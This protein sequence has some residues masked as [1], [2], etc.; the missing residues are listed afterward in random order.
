[1]HPAG[2]ADVAEPG[3]HAEVLRSSG[4]PLEE[5]RSCHGTGYAGG[6]SGSSCVTAGCHTDGVESCGTCHLAEPTTAAHV[7][8]EGQVSCIGCHAPHQN[9]RER[10]HPNGSVEVVLSGLATAAG[11]HPQWESGQ[12]TCSDVYCHGGIERTWVGEGPLGCDGCHGHPPTSHLGFADAATDCASC[13]AGDGHH[14]DGVL[15]V[16]E[17]TC[18]GCHGSGPLGAPPPGLFGVASGGAVGAH[19]RHLDES[20]GDRIGPIVACVECHVVPARADDDGHLDTS[21]PADVRLLH[22]GTYSPVARSCV[23]GCHSDRDPGPEW[24]D[25]S[26]AARECGG[27]HA[28]PPATVASGAAHP[29]VG[30]APADCAPC[31]SFDAATHVDGHVD[32]SPLGC[33]GCHGTG[34]LGAPP[35]GLA[36]ELAGGAVGAHARHLDATLVDRVGRAAR[37]TDCHEVPDSVE[38]D[39]HLDSSP[40]ADVRLWN[41]GSYEPGPRTCVAGCHW[42]RDPGPAWDDDSGAERACDACHG[43]PP[44]T[45]RIGTPHPP[46]APEVAVCVTCHAFEPTTHVDGHVDLASR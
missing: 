16:T 7:A 3:S 40:P 42:D 5:C 22:G 33:D 38:A 12:G 15:D 41:G 2:F 30:S 14:I 10:N 31:H 29:S 19:A 8:H 45:T 11:H 17:G 39:G 21:P 9:A 27:C 34:P 24:D 20:L 13:H 26:G 37:C 25:D 23:V 43:M 4:Y 6:A 35:P 32:V 46:T 36:G 28:M 18:D 44:A 1:M